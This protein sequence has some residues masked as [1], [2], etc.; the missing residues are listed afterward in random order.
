LNQRHA[1]G[2]GPEDTPIGGS[3][4]RGILLLAVA[5][6]LGIVV[7]QASDTGG[8]GGSAQ[9]TTETS[10]SRVPTPTLPSVNTSLA[11]MRPPADVKILPAN[12][13]QISGLGGRVATVLKDSGYTNTLS[14]IDATA[15]AETSLVEYSSPEF[16][17]DAIA[18][19]VILQLPATAVQLLSTPP[20]VPDTRGAE[21]V[22]V[23]GNDLARLSSEGAT[24]TTTIG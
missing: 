9:V 11:P 12:G 7:L 21:V 8:G 13:T 3:G 6:V 15:A 23:A 10:V 18:V 24:T 4:G 14:P 16:A 5:V 22:V 19:A 20:P 2:G 17:S 1:S